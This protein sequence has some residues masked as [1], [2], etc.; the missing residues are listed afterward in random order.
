MELSNN[1]MSNS[2]SQVLD[3]IFD[4][5]FLHGNIIKG[6]DCLHGAFPDYYLPV[7]ENIQV[8]QA[9][10]GNMEVLSLSNNKMMLIKLPQLQDTYDTEIYRI[11]RVNGSSICSV[12][13]QYEKIGN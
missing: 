2:R 12:P 3:I 5:P 11:D 6:D 4:G 13:S 10:F 1:T 9:F 8:S 7:P